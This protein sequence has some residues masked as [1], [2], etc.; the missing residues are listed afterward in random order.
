MDFL[1]NLLPDGVKGAIAA[2]F[3]RILATAAAALVGNWL[4]GLLTK[5]G[6][7]TDGTLGDVVKEISAAVFTTVAG[8]GV[9]T[10]SIADAKNV[11]TK[12]KVAAATAFDVG[13][14]MDG[15]AQVNPDAAKVKAV[16]AAITTADQAAPA[17][18]QAIVD[19]LKSDKF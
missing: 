7:P 2:K 17:T 4:I 3:T 9:I 11:D 10:Y 12:I 15:A 13:V 8:A 6:L 19:S 16:A 14:A 5:Y 18:K 1:K